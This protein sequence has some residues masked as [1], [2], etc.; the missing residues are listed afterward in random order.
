MAVSIAP[1]VNPGTFQ[2]LPQKLV[3]RILNLEFI[4]MSELIPE[5]WKFMEEEISYCHQ[6]RSSHRG[7]VTDILLWVECYSTLVEVLSLQ[8]PAKVRQMMA[9]QKTIL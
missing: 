3:K 1:R 2:D 4:D 5:S 7:P 6:N 8:Y 9:Y